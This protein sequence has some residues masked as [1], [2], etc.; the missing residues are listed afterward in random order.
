MRPREQGLCYNK[1]M[2]KIWIHR[3]NT[4]RAAND[5]DVHY[6]L[7]MTPSQRLQTMQWLRTVH[8]RLK[9]SRIRGKIRKGLR[10]V[11]RRF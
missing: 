1:T 4:F 7:T 10:R 6:Y 9:P 2:G 11:T 8:E 5:F 3:A